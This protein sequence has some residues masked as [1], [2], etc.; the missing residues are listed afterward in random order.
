MYDYFVTTDL[1]ADFPPELSEEGFGI[2]PMS[3]AVDGV[4][5]DGKNRAYL[6][7]HEFYTLLENGKL[8]TTSMVSAEDAY[9]FFADK[10]REGKDVL[11]I[12]F[13]SA[14]SGCYGSYLKAAE[15]ASR[16]FPDRRVAVVDS[17]CASSGEGLLC[18]YVLKKRA[19]GATLDE[20]EAYAN[21]LRDR[22]GHV[23]TVNDMFHLYRGGRVSKGAA[24][25]GQAIKLKPILMV[26][27]E[28]KLI[29]VSNVIGR[30]IALRSLVDKMET[31]GGSRGN[32]C[33]IIS[34]G[35]C[36]EDAEFVAEKVR[37]RFGERRI[38]I[39]DIG[40]VIGS[41]CG[42]GVLALFYLADNKTNKKI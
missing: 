15:K 1:T 36:R 17:K 14:L 5:Y 35:D 27:D 12:S 39:T 16:E 31:D 2:I 22:I 29:P 8:S 41:H 26:N 9:E 42:K 23:F 11:H 28:G 21:K 34:H 32:D 18:Y 37:E 13:S 10:L 40:A 6:T 7:P 4:E 38:I 3:Y 24:I 19:E 20:N 30:K 33:I 25:V